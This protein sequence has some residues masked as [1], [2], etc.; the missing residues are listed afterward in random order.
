LTTTTTGAGVYRREALGTH[1]D[2]NPSL[3][4]LEY[5]RA[6]QPDSPSG[7][8]LITAWVNERSGIGWRAGQGA[9]GTADRVREFSGPDLAE[10]HAES[11]SARMLRRVRRRVRARMNPWATIALKTVCGG[12][13]VLLFAALAE[14]LK[15][16]RFAGIF[17]AAPTVALAGLIIGLIDKGPAEQAVSAR[18][19][20]AGAVGL[21]AYSLIAV[22]ALNRL[23]PAKGAS[24]AGLGW[25]VTSALT[26]L[27]VAP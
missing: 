24:I 7:R 23:G 27:A 15:P 6:V 13:L 3:L 2:A 18:T 8:A 26:Y 5:R 14:M 12:A 25:L 19:M 11:A 22:P 9:P 4:A 1:T 16:K 21:T 10:G 20:I 17:G